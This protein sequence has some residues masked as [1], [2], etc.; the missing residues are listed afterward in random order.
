M[1]NASRRADVTCQLKKRATD[2][3]RKLGPEEDYALPSTAPPPRPPTASEVREKI[4]LL[5][6]TLGFPSLTADDLRKL[7]ALVLHI[8]KGTAVEHLTPL[9]NSSQPN[10]S[11]NAARLLD[12]LDKD[13]GR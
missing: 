1:G 13:N 11:T 6:K 8:G 7:K 2:N 10:V 3:Y 5:I 12:W 9:R 4:Q